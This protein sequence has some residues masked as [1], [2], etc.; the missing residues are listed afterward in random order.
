MIKIRN[1]LNNILL[2]RVLYSIL[3]LIGLSMLIFTLARLLPGDPARLALGPRAPEEVV[4]KYREMLHLDKPIYIQYFYW[5]N[6]VFHLSLG[7]SLVTFRDVSDDIAEFL[8]ATI[9]LILLAGIILVIGAFILGV[10][11]GRKPGSI[12]DNFMRMF[13]YIGISI[14]AFVWAI[15][16]QLIF[17]YWFN[18]FPAVGRI[19]D[20]ITP[21]PRITGLMTVDSMLSGNILAFIDS[22]KHLI[23]PA[24]ALAIG[25]IAQDARILRANLVENI[26]KDYVLNLKSHGISERII[27]FKYALKPSMIPVITVMGLDIASLIG[28]AFLV[29]VIFN[30]PGLSRY[31]ITA[32]LRK[33]LNAIVGVTLVVGV[34]FIIANLIVDL[35]IYSLDPRIKYRER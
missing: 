21:P 24:L 13:A 27:Y 26:G 31:G 12:V 9:E 8:P 30:W 29:E 19:S 18:I 17:A 22:I 28:N 25:P 3:V 2:R 14:P 34:V 15:I 11:S 23:L 1:I 10:I 20:N 35:I 7:Q 32:M 5:L 16:F 6:D 4:Q 33:D